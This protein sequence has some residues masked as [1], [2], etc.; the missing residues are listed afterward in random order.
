[1]IVFGLVSAIGLLA[2]MFLRIAWFGTDDD[3][4]NPIFFVI[5]IV[6]AIIFVLAILINNVSGSTQPIKAA[7]DKFRAPENWK[8]I[9]DQVIPPRFFCVG[10]VACPSLHRTWGLDTPLTKIEFEK[11][12]SNSRLLLPVDSECIESP[13]FSG[14]VPLC[15]ANGKID[16]FETSITFWQKDHSDTKYSVVLLME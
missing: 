7:A 12:L 2:D 9:G 16:N 14:S 8:L 15:T 4:P 3:N 5:G 1:M 6:A 13:R 11:L 10:D